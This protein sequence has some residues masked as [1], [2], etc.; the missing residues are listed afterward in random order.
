MTRREAVA[1][2]AA[3]SAAAQVPAGTGYWKITPELIAAHDAGVDDL[4][5]RQTV[6]ASSPRR[7]G[8]PDRYGLHNGGSAAST[9]LSLVTCLTQPG[10]RHY[11]SDLVQE[12]LKLALGFLERKLTPDGNVDLLFTNLN[13]PPDTAFSM[14][15]MCPAVHLARK[16]NK[17]EI[18]RAVAP[19]MK[20]M[21]DAIARG[22]VHTPNHRWV[23]C[24]A[25]AQSHALFPTPAWLKRVDDWLMEGIDI[26]ADGQYSERSTLAYNTVVDRALVV[27]ATKLGRPQLLDPVRR[28]L[29]SLM[30]LLHPENEVVTEISKRQDQYT[31]GSVNA[32][33]IAL[34][35]LALKDGNGQY[36]TLARLGR[37]SLAELMEYP[38][39]TAAGPEP[40]PIPTDYEK[41][42]P[43][44]GIARIRRGDT[45]ATVMMGGTSRLFSVRR[46]KAIINAVRFAGSF[47]GKGQFVPARAERTADG[48]V[49]TQT[50]DAGYYQ[51]F[52]DGT[53]QP[54]GVDVWY[55]MR[56][57][58]QR[59][60]VCTIEYHA[61]LKELPGGFRLRVSAKGTR[62]LPVTIEIGLHTDGEL[63]GCEAALDVTDG[64]LLPTGKEATLRVGSDQIRFGPGRADHQYTQVRGAEAKLPG[65]SVYLT[66]YAPFDHTMEFKW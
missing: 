36:E 30:Y 8:I 11:T 3:L 22:G 55:K 37:P 26:D 62:D 10:S 31:R 16:A 12:R 18:E 48:Y 44:V 14:Y 60:E 2:G 4:L 63:S 24:A 34:R 53:K 45:S 50:I 43:A 19:L 1:F 33:W 52:G 61:E 64:Y 41:V 9:V 15:A 58:R 42:M 32:Y 46:G 6:D 7:G 13:S 25:L 56:E 39:L 57:R 5:K 21:A 59:T 49:W 20:R 38:E 51:P 17:P 47:F 35:T 27:T 23:M 54:V 40:K 66:G 29:D 65:R 28:N